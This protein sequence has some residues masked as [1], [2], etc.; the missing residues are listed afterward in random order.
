MTKKN[1]F[2]AE[3]TFNESYSFSLTKAKF[4]NLASN[5]KQVQVN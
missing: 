3:L 1:N 5:M 2:R 4:Q